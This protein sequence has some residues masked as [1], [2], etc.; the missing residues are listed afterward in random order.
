MSLLRWGAASRP[1]SSWE[2]GGRTK[3]QF[4]VFPED[5]HWAPRTL[6]FAFRICEMGLS[7]GAGESGPPGQQGVVGNWLRLWGGAGATSEPVPPPPLTPKPV[8][9]GPVVCDLSV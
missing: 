3:L 4:W 1:L 8:C 5:T 9:S 2:Q 6:S 7:W